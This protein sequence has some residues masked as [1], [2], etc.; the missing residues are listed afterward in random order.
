MNSPLVYI[1]ILNYRNYTDTIE[2][3]HS[4]EA[5]KYSN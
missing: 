4:V 3:V 2:C 5:V 1:I